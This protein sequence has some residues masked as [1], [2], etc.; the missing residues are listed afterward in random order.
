MKQVKK[1]IRYINKDFSNFR[2]DL[3]NFS[4]TYFPSTYNDFTPESTGMLFMEMSAYLG[5]VLSFYLDNQIQE[6]YL[7]YARQKENLFKLAYTLGY[8][9]K[10]TTAA[11]A[12]IS[13]YQ[14][15][16]AK[17]SGSVTV[18]ENTISVVVTGGES[19]IAYPL[20]IASG[21]IDPNYPY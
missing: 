8:T 17:L 18:G 15:V 2:N 6:T 11:T 4:K 20:T 12:E 7:Q 16:P 1:D 9:P 21:S 19:P 3:I 10:V 13:F 5:D 14:Q